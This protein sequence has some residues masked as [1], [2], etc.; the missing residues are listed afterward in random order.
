MSDTTTTEFRIAPGAT[1]HT[2]SLDIGPRK[3]AG[4]CEANGVVHAWKDGPT[5]TVDPPIHTRYCKNCG[6][7]QH[8]REAWF[9][10]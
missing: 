1:T 7:Q 6:K 4:W 5:L 10:V 8:K 2:V 3:E 9:D